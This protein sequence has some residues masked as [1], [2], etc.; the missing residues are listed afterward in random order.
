MAPRLKVTKTQMLAAK[1]DI[2]QAAVNDARTSA[3]ICFNRDT[4]YGML[5]SNLPPVL[6]Q[7]A[8]VDQKKQ[9]VEEYFETFLGSFEQSARHRQHVATNSRKVVGEGSEA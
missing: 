3:N 5:V 9:L 6:L 4:V 1:L 7:D 2:G 8:T